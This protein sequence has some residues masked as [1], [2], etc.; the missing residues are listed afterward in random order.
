LLY[1][2]QVLCNSRPKGQLCQEDGRL[3]LDQLHSVQCSSVSP[4]LSWRENVSAAN[5]PKLRINSDRLSLIEIMQN[6]ATQRVDKACCAKNVVDCVSS[7]EQ[8]SEFDLQS[9]PQSLFGSLHVQQQ[10]CDA[11]SS[12]LTNTYSRNDEFLVSPIECETPQ[13]SK[14]SCA[15]VTATSDFDIDPEELEELTNRVSIDETSPMPV[16]LPERSL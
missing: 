10:T 9:S 1:A 2:Q 8:V 4:L 11:L 6:Y 7:S 14:Q 13:V 16:R 3:T 12:T 15:D 5:E